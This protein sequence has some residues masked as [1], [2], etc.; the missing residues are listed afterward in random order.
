MKNKITKITTSILDKVIIIYFIFLA[1]CFITNYSFILKDSITNL[2]TIGMGFI[3]L[4]SIRW[5]IDKQSF[6]NSI[7]IKFLRYLAGLNDKVLL[8]L[9]F[10]ISM[11]VFFQIG[12]FRHFAFSSGMDMGA[13]DQAIW[14]TIHKG[15]ILFTSL[16]GNI[17]YLGAHFSLILLLIAPF[18]LIGD[19]AIILIFLQAAAIGI[20]IFPLYLI[21]KQ[22]LNNRLLVFVFIFAFFLSKPLRG[23]GL[24]DFHADVFLIPLV[25][26]SYYLLITKRIFWAVSA[27]IL[28]LCCKE[29][30]AILVFAYGIFTITYLKR[31]Y[32][33]ASLLALGIG[34]W[35]TVTNLIMPHLAYTESY[36][37]INWL[38]FGTTYTDNLLAIIK[39]PSLPIKL[40]FSSETIEYCVKF[41]VPL[42]LLSF[43]SPQHYILF[44]L[45]L[46]FNIL[47]GIHHGG[48]ITITSHYPAQVLPFIFISA[49]YGAGKLIDL[50]NIK[51]N[52]RNIAKKNPFFMVW[53][54]IKH[55][56]TTEN[57][58]KSNLKSH[59]SKVNFLVGAMIILLSLGFF[60]KSDGHK[61]SKFIYSTNALHSNEIRRALKKIPQEASVSA[62]HRITPHLAHRK[63][64]YL[65]ENNLDTR[66]LVEYVVL[67][68]QLIEKDKEHFDQTIIKLKEKGFEEIYRD[69]HEELYILFNSKYKKENLKDIQ[70]KILL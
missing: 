16:P 22:R 66:Y 37:Y 34:W 53:E 30:A 59:L 68:R 38:P 6:S 9:I 63:Y 14:N 10:V 3:L 60:G 54:S 70:R 5:F 26:T 17:N 2:S 44:L 62:V 58:T 69:K 40:F 27:I 11:S 1:G 8:A 64:L 4:L 43:L 48:M 29:S 25:F 35:V 13:A 55:F 28:M 33:G 45:P 12:L 42:G 50:L 32:L 57:S 49:I 18:Y 21:A 19:G 15:G 65:W 67:H 23:V 41:F 46:A 51:L 39:N 31:Y 61:L 56:P 7:F 36:P 24:L 20:S 52:N 47:G